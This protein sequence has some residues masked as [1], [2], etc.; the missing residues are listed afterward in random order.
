MKNF[1]VAVCIPTYN[2]ADYLLR[3]VESVMKQTYTPT[4]IWIS[5]DCSTDRTQEVCCD[6]VKLY[7][8]IKYYRQP[9]NL[10]MSGNPR[11]VVKQP[12]TDLIAKLDSDDEYYPNYLEEMINLISRYENA[13][14]VHAAT[15]F[16]D[17]YNQV[18]YTSRLAR[19]SEFVSSS[20]AFHQALSG[21]RVTANVV[22]YRRSVLELV[23]FFK[24]DLDFCD[25]WDIGVRIAAAGWGNAYTN[26]VLSKYRV[27]DDTKNTRARRR[28]AQVRCSTRV[29]KESI[30]P[31]T[32]KFGVPVSTVS[33]HRNSLAFRHSLKRDSQFN[34]LEKSDLAS[35]IRELAS[36]PS[37]FY[38]GRILRALGGE[39]LLNYYYSTKSTIKNLI[40]K[41]N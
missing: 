25:D 1:S 23:D 22:L 15:E 16:I 35:A 2:Q 32:A 9:K 6:L 11:W 17:K 8:I 27:W 13:G 18:L 33:K 12:K 28:I 29:Y 36:S 41:N 26:Q 5:D 31:N 20:T 7:P 4:E 3:S 40:F 37:A 21:F 38:F 39:Y 14:Y 19:N 30:C 34:E 24:T 10:G